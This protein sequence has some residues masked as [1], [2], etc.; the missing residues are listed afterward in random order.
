MTVVGD[1]V[2]EP[3][4]FLARVG[5]PIGVLMDKAKLTAEPAGVLLGGP[6]MGLSAFSTEVPVTKGTSGILVRAAMARGE[7]R[8]CIRCGSCVSVCPARLTPND[9][10]VAGEVQRWDMTEHYHVDDCIECGCCSYVCPA[11]RPIVQQIRHS[12]SRLWRIRSAK[13]E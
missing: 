7:F 9:I 10:S 12:K 5:T 1:G 6:M 4:N 2:S 3:G 8:D 13:K 11:N